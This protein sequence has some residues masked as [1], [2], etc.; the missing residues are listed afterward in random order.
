MGRGPLCVLLRE[1]V[2]LELHPAIDFP[3]LSVTPVL[4]SRTSLPPFW[5]ILRDHS[6]VYMPNTILGIIN[7]REV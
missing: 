6:V 7:K 5:K 1:W 2:H 3:S 4:S